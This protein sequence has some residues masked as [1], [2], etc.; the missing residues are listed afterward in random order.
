MSDPRIRCLREEEGIV[1]LQMCDE[2]HKNALSDDFVGELEAPLAELAA[3][4][5]ARVIIL[6]GLPEVFCAGGH[7]DTLLKL[8]RGEITTTDLM[9]SRAVLELPVPTIAAMEGHAVG[10]G[11]TLGL[12]CDIVLMARQSRYG[13]SFMNMGFTPGMGTTRLLQLAVGEYLAAEMMYGGQFFRGNHFEGR[14]GINYV[15]PRTQV[16]SKALAIARRIADKPRFALELLKR[17][18]SLAKRD[19]FERART[20]ETMMHEIC[21]AR[22]ETVAMIE[23]NYA[24]PLQSGPTSAV[25][26]TPAAK[27]RAPTE[28]SDA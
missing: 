20:S 18:L 25:G 2:Q 10:G 27:D 16:Q 22:P 19:A 23:E 24:Q 5:E 3:D 7:Q 13:C 8:A 26:T 4:R 15:L 12:C 1:V 14:G 11:L 28:Q 17:S 6:A 9:L 21:F